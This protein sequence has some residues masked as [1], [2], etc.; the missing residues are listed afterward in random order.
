MNENLKKFLEEA[1][2]NEELKT[3]LEALT[4][5]DTAT[6]KAIEIAKEYGFTLTAEDFKETQG[7][8][9]SDDELDQVAGGGCAIMGTDPMGCLFYGRG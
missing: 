2:K 3:K 7:A 5:K 9:L 6:E 1:S 8:V 4:D